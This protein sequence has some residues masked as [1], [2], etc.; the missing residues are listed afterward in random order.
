MVGKL[1]KAIT[2]NVEMRVKFATKPEK[3]LLL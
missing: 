2:K 1:D 3:Y